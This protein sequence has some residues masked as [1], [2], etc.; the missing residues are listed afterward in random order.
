VSVVGVQAWRRFL[1]AAPP[2]VQ[3]AWPLLKLAALLDRVTAALEGSYGLYSA[4][5]TYEVPVI[6]DCWFGCD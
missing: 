4:L 3:R 2:L 1:G 6:L 5:S